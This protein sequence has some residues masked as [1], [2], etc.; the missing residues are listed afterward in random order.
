M[1][2]GLSTCGSWA[3]ALRLS[4]CGD[5]VSCSAACGIFPDQGLNLYVL[6]WQ[7]DSVPLSQQGSPIFVLNS[8]FFNLFFPKFLPNFPKIIYS[9]IPH[10]ILICTQCCKEL[11]MTKVKIQATII[12]HLILFKK[13]KLS[14][15][16]LPQQ[17]SEMVSNIAN[18]ITS[19]I[20]FHFSN[21]LPLF[22]W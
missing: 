10:L 6:L 22:L 7:V 19:Q 15:K 12:S 3:I 11:D 16:S 4:S 18:I 9:I 21:G 5:R 14:S 1:V 13:K 17:Q 8:P 2:H 20:F